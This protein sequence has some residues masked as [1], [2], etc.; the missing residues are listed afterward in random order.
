MKHLRKKKELPLMRYYE[1]H[2]GYRKVDSDL[3]GCYRLDWKPREED[4]DPP[5]HRTLYF[6][7]E[8]IAFLPYWKR[9]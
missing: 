8:D 2:L 4:I 9:G 7:Y 1:K 5:K 3:P 6:N